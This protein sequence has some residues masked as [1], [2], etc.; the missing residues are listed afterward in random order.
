[1]TAQQFS[2]IKSLAARE[3]G[4]NVMRDYLVLALDQIETGQQDRRGTVELVELLR[5]AL[6]IAHARMEALRG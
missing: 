4:W 5:P 3:A 6:Q 1:M 2:Q